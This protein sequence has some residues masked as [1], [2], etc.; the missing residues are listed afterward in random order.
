MAGRITL[1]KCKKFFQAKEEAAEVASLDTSNILS[2][3]W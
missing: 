3:G 1:E 2:Q